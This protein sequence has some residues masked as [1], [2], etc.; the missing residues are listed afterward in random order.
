MYGTLTL[1]RSCATK[2]VMTDYYMLDIS[3]KGQQAISDCLDA[4]AEVLST[5]S[6]ITNSE[7]PLPALASPSERS[8]P[9]KPAPDG[10]EDS[11][12]PSKCLWDTDLLAE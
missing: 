9:V 10:G 4:I 6:G 3:E 11:A 8:C 12:S 1:T 7:I 5:E 2:L